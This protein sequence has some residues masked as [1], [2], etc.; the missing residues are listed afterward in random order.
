MSADNLTLNTSG[1]L[2]RLIAAGLLFAVVFTALAHGAVEPW[3]LLFFELIV[4]TLMFLWAAKIV[5][6]KQ[7]IIT[8]PAVA[9]PMVALAA[10]GLAQSV[11]FTDGAGIRRSLSMDVEATRSTVTA[12]LFLLVTFLIAANFFASRRRLSVLSGFLVVFGLALAVFALVQNFTWNGKFYWLRP[13]T[14]SASPFGPFVNHNHFAGY[15]ELLIPIPVALMITRAVRGE[16]RVLYGFIAAVMGV[17]AIASL[18]RGGMISLAAQMLFLAF[19]SIWLPRSRRHSHR[20]RSSSH[21]ARQSRIGFSGW[22]KASVPQ[23]VAVLIVVAGMV[24]GI[25]WIGGTD[26]VINRVTQRQRANTNQQVETFVESRGWVWQDTLAMIRANPVLGVG[27]GAYDT[28][29]SIYSERDGSI[30]VPQ[31]HNDYLQIVADCG[32]AGGLIA[33]WFLVVIFRN[34][35]RGIRARDPMYAGLALGGGT[36]IS[37]LLVHSLFDFNLQLP[38]NA[39]L[40]L[41]MTAVVSHISSAAAITEDERELERR[42]EEARLSMSVA[43]KSM[44]ARQ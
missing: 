20:A 10:I 35:S 3:S 24:W 39:L 21:D 26:S 6:D 2:S 23:A 22:L 40:F 41:F 17:A 28:A 34:I 32:I 14:A 31:A 29:F 7:F 11:A 44:A 12:L 5:I 8:V 36:A 42:P 15:M 25:I 18:S 38:S 43:A 27:L 13:N 9:L 19:M 37:G 4:L 16:T 30:R 33:L 1:R